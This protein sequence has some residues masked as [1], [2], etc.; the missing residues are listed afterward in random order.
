MHTHTHILSHSHT[1]IY[2]HLRYL[3][4]QYPCASAPELF[5][6]KLKY[7]LMNI[8]ACRVL[9][10]RRLAPCKSTS[11]ATRN[12]IKLIHKDDRGFLRFR[13]IFPVSIC[14]RVGDEGQWCFLWRKPVWQT[15]WGFLP[16]NK[17]KLKKTH[18]T[19][20]FL[21]LTKTWKTRFIFPTTHLLSSCVCY[22]YKR[23]LHTEK[24]RFLL[25]LMF[26]E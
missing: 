23:P 20:M 12:K 11:L 6:L 2:L 19:C 14:G 18:R 13:I 3:S 17:S 21:L 25:G 10:R 22:R 7:F 4:T 8:S 1:V 9:S 5:P 24:Q 26:L 16:V 15:L